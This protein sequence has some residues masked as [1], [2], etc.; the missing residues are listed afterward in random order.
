VMQA[1]GQDALVENLSWRSVALWLLGYP[2]AARA[3]ADRT[4]NYARE[5]GQAATLMHALSVPFLT[6][7][8][9]GD[10]ASAKAEL[11]LLGSKT[12]ALVRE[13][14]GRLWH[15]WISALTGDATEAVQL[16]SAGLALFRST[17]STAWIPLY[18]S[19]LA[20]IH[21]QLGQFDEAWRC[22]D[23][24]MAAV[25]RTGERWN[26]AELHRVAGEIALMSPEPDIAKAEIAFERSLAISR[27]QEARSWELRAAMSMARLWRDQGRRER[28]YELL[29]A[30]F[31]WFIEGF[32]TV[33]LRDA[34]ALLDELAI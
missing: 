11:V 5:L 34:R 23:E 3:D 19:V 31:G 1:G 12:G 17:R 29:A 15:G 28:A 21:A 16:M 24:A 9:C 33:D 22:I 32:D 26:E 27:T 7:I 2:D 6:R 10:Y 4:V 14:F 20:R 8:N 30:V 18:L 13:A 25:E